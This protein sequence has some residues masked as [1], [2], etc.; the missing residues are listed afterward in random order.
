VWR[1]VVFASVLILLSAPV[2]V[3]LFVGWV[4]V[5]GAYLVSVVASDA[6]SVAR[7]KRA[8]SW[9]QSGGASM[10]ALAFAI[11]LLS[12]AALWLFSH[13]HPDQF[14]TCHIVALQF[15]RHPA[16]QECEAF[17]TTDFVVPIVLVVV[18]ALFASDGDF[19]FTFPGFGTFER[20]RA[21]KKAAKELQ[22]EAPELDRR[23]EEFLGALNP[24]G[25]SESDR[26]V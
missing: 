21:G 19:T 23:R 8:T 7:S 6:M 14:G 13:L 16:A 4:V 1:R 25:P 9:R 11:A 26:G 18:A 20:T 22:E 2:L 5:G 17:G 12:V 10:K 15:G 24:L 3:V